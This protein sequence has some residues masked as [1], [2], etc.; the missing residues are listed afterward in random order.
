MQDFIETSHENITR[1]IGP[2]EDDLHTQANKCISEAHHLVFQALPKIIKQII[3][4]EI[5]REKNHTSFGEYAL[6][7]SSCGLNITNNHKLWLL[8]SAMEVN[9]RHTP[10][11]GD[12]LHEIDNS[13]RVYAKENKVQMKKL[14]RSLYEFDN[15]E[16]PELNETITYLPSRSNSP[17]GQLLKLRNQDQDA[18]TK[19]VKGEMTL[20][21]AL[22]AKPKKQLDPIESAKNKFN[23]LSDVEREA[24]LVWVEEQMKD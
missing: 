14:S 4:Q 20:K 8:K 16:E 3:E 11:W 18:Y 2:S 15:R 7:Q 17:D 13:V 1:T 12:I 22:P 23:S 19:V 9:G 5:W 10:E 24:F 6:K 21:D